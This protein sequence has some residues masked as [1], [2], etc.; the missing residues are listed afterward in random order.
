MQLS[1][2]QSPNENGERD[3]LRMAAISEARGMAAQ[4]A[5]QSGGTSHAVNVGLGGAP[6]ALVARPVL[7]ERSAA[8]KSIRQFIGGQTGYSTSDG[9]VKGGGVGD[10]DET[11]PILKQIKELLERN[12]S[13]NP[14]GAQLDLSGA[15]MMLP[16]S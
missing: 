11:V 9:R 6:D 4:L 2:E 8:L 3:N 15:R 14:H 13:D 10:L 12:L 16:N 1:I 5:F 7:E